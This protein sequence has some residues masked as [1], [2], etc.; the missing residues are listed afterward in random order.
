MTTRP[1]P[2]SR[3]ETD[4]YRAASAAL[5]ERPAAATRSAILAAAAR[6]VNAKPHAV[7][8]TSAWRWRVPLAAAATVLISTVAI[9]LAQRTQQQMPAIIAESAPPPAPARPEAASTAK[10]T[11]SDALAGA[12]GAP[13]AAA[14]A[15]RQDANAARSAPSRPIVATPRPA[16]FGA[17]AD[18]PPVA[19]TGRGAAADRA[20]AER[21]QPPVAQTSRNEA[22]ASVE[23]A[24]A[25]GKATAAEGQPAA[26]ATVGSVMR[27]ERSR[28][29]E[30]RAPAVGGTAPAL[31]KA[32]TPE[33][34]LVRIIELRQ[35]A[36]D[37][38]ADAELKKLRELHPTLVIPE[39]ALRRTATR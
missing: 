33:R 32:E 8:A 35:A 34:W 2:E 18:L 19:G 6:A 20:S 37:E 13:A 23:Q 29:L 1:Q 12:P 22:A 3:A 9:I 31:S 38:E 25:G 4:A 26:P 5:D 15:V 28:A 24:A 36:R 30:R 39:S 17:R 27:D 7:G 10:P 11:E 21:E 16:E 14:T